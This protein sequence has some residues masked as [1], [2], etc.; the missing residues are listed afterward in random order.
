MDVTKTLHRQKNT[1]KAERNSLFKNY[2]QYCLENHLN[3]D[4][5]K[6]EPKLISSLL[7]RERRNH[8]IKT[9]CQQKESSVTKKDIPDIENII[10]NY[11]FKTRCWK[12]RSRKS[13]RKQKQERKEQ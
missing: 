5:P 13:P 7:N 6:K 4:P 12:T 8:I 10:N 9:K 3:T 11:N 2:I 1:L